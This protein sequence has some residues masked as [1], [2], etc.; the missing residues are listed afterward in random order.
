MN[1][2]KIL[3]IMFIL[4]GVVVSVNGFD[5]APTN[6]YYSYDDD[7][8]TSGN[9]LDLSGNGFTGTTTGATTGVDGKLL[10]SFFYDGSNDRVAF[11]DLTGQVVNGIAFWVSPNVTS[12][13]TADFPFIMT[14]G[15]AGEWIGLRSDGGGNTYHFRKVSSTA[16]SF[17]TSSFTLSVDTWTYLAL[18]YDNT[19]DTLYVYR[20]GVIVSS[21]TPSGSNTDLFD[22][23]G[24]EGYTGFNNLNTVYWD[25]QIDELM[26]YSENL[27]TVDILELYNSGAGFN[28][29]TAIPTLTFTNITA[30][31]ITFI[32]GTF[33]NDSIEF[34]TTV[35]NSSTNGN[36]NQS[37]TLTSSNNLSI[38]MNS[39]SQTTITNITTYVSND[40]TSQNAYCFQNTG[41]NYITHTINVLSV[42]IAVWNGSAWTDGTGT[43]M[44]GA[45]TCGSS[46]G[47]VQ[48][49][50]NNL[51]GDF[52]LDLITGTYNIFFYANNNETNVSSNFTFIVDKTNP[53]INNSIPSEINTYDFDGS[54]FS[55]TDTNLASCN[56]SIDGFNIASGVNFT[57]I[58]NG[59]LSYNITAIDLVG[60]S[61]VE[62][63][64]LF[65]NPFQ[66]FNFQ[67]NGGSPITNYVFGGLN[68]SNTASI[69]TY[70]S[71]ISL[72]N[73]TVLFEKLGF[74]STNVAFNLNTTSII[75]ITTNV[76]NSTIVIRIFDRETGLILTGLTS[77]TLQATTG[78]NGSTTTGFLNISDI[79]FIN[80]QYQILA[81][82]TGYDTENVFFNYNN[83]EIINVDI[84]M[85]NTTGDE[86]GQITIVVKNSLSQFV[87]S[88]VCS[89]LQWQPSESAF[90]S[91]AQGLTNVIGETMLNIQLNNVIYKFSCTKDTFTTITNAQVIQIDESSLTIILD[92]VIL[93]PTTLFP[94]LVTSLTN[95]TIN[96]THQLITYNFADSDGLTTEAC[97][98]VFLVN[99]NRRNFETENCV[100]T[101]TGTILLTVDVNQ[102]SNI[103]IQGIL[104]TSEVIDYVTDSITIQGTGNLAGQLAKIGMDVIIP[105]ML[106]LLG[107]GLGILLSKIEI[108]VVFM[109]VA[110]WVSVAFVPTILKS[111]IAMFI[112]VVVALMLWLGFN[113]K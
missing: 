8:L 104:T 65:V 26:F 47:S 96:S 62:P 36:V 48:Y 33:F 57:L 100:S 40:I 105:T 16:P 109:A 18:T 108:A 4:L 28:P 11:P 51:T 63:G 81:E 42:P 58:N 72:G 73:N 2:K 103:L 77:I 45:M 17:I 14:D 5:T 30:N 66:F 94:N 25:G 90:I 53:I 32:N 39:T 21:Q 89:A 75:N 41:T 91:V 3:T 110:G 55:C 61:I 29:Y 85:L 7:D 102:T 87:E 111:T 1:M 15:G 60:N 35:L 98:Q 93:A 59:N 13:N 97:L 49:A 6:L 24:S 70:N 37:Y 74:T 52:T 95:T 78:F 10:Q 43:G 19:T 86:S 34:Q 67:T 31:D 22:Q 107:L 9:P 44:Q 80:E 99:G 92:D 50:T 68:F 83:Q 76:T 20:N 106:L 112:T 46:A 27:T 79:N 84:F 64:V 23:I 88:A 82:H 38:E 113:R 69:S 71:I 12:S 56:I 54:L 101:S